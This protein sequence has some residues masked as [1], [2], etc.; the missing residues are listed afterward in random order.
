M[1]RRNPR[2]TNGGRPSR[3]VPFW[4]AAA[5]A[6]VLVRVAFWLAYRHTPIPFGPV[7]DSWLYL[8]LARAWNAS[9]QWTVEAAFHSPLYPY[10]LGWALRPGGD[11]P[12]AMLL[13]QNLAGILSSVLV[14]VW[15]RRL[16]SRAWTSW[17]VLALLVLSGPWIAYEWRLFPVSLA[18][19]FQ[20]LF[21]ESAYRLRRARTAGSGSAVLGFA[22]AGGVL[23][24]ILILLRPNFLLLLPLFAAIGILTARRRT[25]PGLAA[26]AWVLVPLL[27]AAPFLARNHALGAGW[28]LSANSG[29]TFYQG[30]NLRASGGYAR[31]AGVSADITRQN[32]DAAGR[33]EDGIPDSIPGANRYWWN[34]GLSYLAG[35]PLAAIRLWGAKLLLLI[36]PVETG[37]DIPYS[38]EMR[39]VPL[40]AWF[41]PVAFTLLLALAAVGLVRAQASP[42]P[43]AEFAALLLVPLVTSLVFYAMTRYRL[44]A[45]PLLL[46]AAAPGLEETVRVWTR[47]AG[48]VSA[49]RRGLV[50]G[51]VLAGLVASGAALVAGPSTSARVSGWHNWA[52]AAEHSGDATEAVRAY[53]HALEILPDQ[54]ETLENLSRIQLNRGETDRAERT[55][56]TLLEHHPDSFAGHNN[57][58]AIHLARGRWEEARREARR[59][60]ELQPGERATYLIL[61]EATARLGLMDEACEAL[62]HLP[63]L[64]PRYEHLIRIRERCGQGGTATPPRRP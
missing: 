36:G 27:L 42:L 15:A 19:L 63:N 46:V 45:W 22:M 61:A 23:A 48:A 11:S 6:L 31:V 50:T 37:G 56:R 35:H 4:T 3:P 25:A 41:S 32:L 59:A 57:L 64:S 16:S 43:R 33:G 30:N 54:R 62:A 52:V 51:A 47:R 12:V 53:Y 34:R 38:F 10:L 40:L 55:L 20:L 58:A 8:G 7:S 44:P 60:L 26:L 21:L 29:I 18:A 39:Q 17:G 13:L 14:L 28:S 2:K 9:G 5:A 1:T 24:G 49:R